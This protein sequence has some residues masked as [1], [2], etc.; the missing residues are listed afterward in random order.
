MG[1]EW[2]EA[3]TI[4]VAHVAIGWAINLLLPTCGN[5][6]A[7]KTT[8]QQPIEQVTSVIKENTQQRWICQSPSNLTTEICI[9]TTTETAA[10]TARTMERV[11]YGNM[12]RNQ[13]CTVQ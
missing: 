11:Q 5:S 12:G 3:E 1:D 9:E 6:M 2:G 8:N 4:E 10:D 13:A 7:C